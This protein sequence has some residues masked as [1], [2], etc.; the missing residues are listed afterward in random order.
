MFIGSVVK[1]VKYYD[2]F[3]KVGYLMVWLMLYKKVGGRLE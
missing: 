2:V 3:W 1:N